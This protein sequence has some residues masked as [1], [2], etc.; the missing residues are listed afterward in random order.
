MRAPA[1]SF[2]PIIGTPIDEARSMT[3]WIFSAKTSPSAPPKTVKSW[4]NTQTRRP[5][6]VPNPVITPS[7]YGRCSSSPMPWD[8]WRASMS[9]SWK[10]PSSSRYSTRSRAVILPL[11]WCFS[12]ARGDP[13]LRASSRR[14][15]SSSSRRVIGTSMAPEGSGPVGRGPSGGRAA[16]PRRGCSR[17]P[18]CGRCSVGRVHPVGPAPHVGD[19]AL[20]A[21]AQVGGD[22]LPHVA[23]LEFGVPRP[24]EGVAVHR[25]DGTARTARA[26]GRLPR[27]GG[28]LPPF[29]PI[30]GSDQIADDGDR[31]LR[32]AWGVEVDPP[33]SDA[34]T[35]PG[36][37][38][39]RVRSRAPDPEQ[40]HLVPPLELGP[41]GQE[42]AH[43]GHRP[44]LAD[45]VGTT[46]Q[47]E[48]ISG[49]GLD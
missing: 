23:P 47:P 36:H 24:G 17:T 14:S 30:D 40:H 37:L 13:A 28:R 9:S 3:L 32:R 15:A 8:R 41:L 34:P 44:A 31:P 48:C 42:G 1:P 10:E 22:T 25:A 7:V 39:G 16:C 11:E 45:G 6:M 2:S 20:C 43:L 18:T 5:S 27:V 46:G 21:H 19:G 12:T 33:P 49:G 4:L 35:V 26:E 29:D 38:V